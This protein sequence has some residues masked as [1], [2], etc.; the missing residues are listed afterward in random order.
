M[1]RTQSQAGIRKPSTKAKAQFK[2][3]RQNQMS[4]ARQIG[5]TAGPTKPEI[6]NNDQTFVLTQAAVN[7]WS[8]V[9][10][11]NTIGQGTAVGER[12]G[13]KIVL[14]SLLVRWQGP[15]TT[16]PTRMMVVYDH[17][18][19]GA[20]PAITDILTVNNINGVNVLANSDRFLILK[21]FYPA[22]HIPNGLATLAESFF[23][24][25]ADGGLQNI[26]TDVIG[27]TIAATSTGAIY[28]MCCSA[29]GALATINCVS[30]IRYSD[31]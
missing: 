23:L 27:G 12:I 8:L 7:T 20:L 24:K 16:Q 28:I 9:Q 30:R 17:S 4:M 25:F 15:G 3:P 6:K 13:R 22:S 14:K 1:K 10:H 26:W 2:R 11:V 19:N 31:S 18:P 21:D 5:A 29:G